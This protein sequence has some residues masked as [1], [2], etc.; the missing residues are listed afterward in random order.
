MVDRKSGEQKV[1]IT[2]LPVGSIGDA[3]G[4]FQKRQGMMLRVA[5][6]VSDWTKQLAIAREEGGEM[7][8]ILED[9]AV[10]LY[11]KIRP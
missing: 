10:G 1:L 9:R 11:E 4:G 8:L 3:S 6:K 5:H 7:T 2:T